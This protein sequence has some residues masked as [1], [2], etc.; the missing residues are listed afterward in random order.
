MIK[1]LAVDRLHVVGDIFDRGPRADSIM[2]ILMQRRSVDIEWGNHDVLWMGAASGSECCIAAVL[3]N[4]LSYGNTT[5][6]ERGYG[7]PLRELALFAG[8][9]YPQLPLDK[10]A[11]HA[12]TVIMFTLEGQL[13]VTPTEE[14]THP[15]DYT[16]HIAGASGEKC[17][18]PTI[19]NN[20]C[21]LS[22]A[23]ETAGAVC[24]YEITRA[25]EGN[26]VQL[27]STADY[28]VSVWAT[29]AGYLDSDVATTTITM[30]RGD[31]NADGVVSITDAVSVV[32]II[33]SG[34]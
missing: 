32:N 22:F 20:N 10:A 11:A 31:V 23:C 28:V 19:T 30:K 29:K 14:A 4:C 2:E 25:G 27:S 9:N 15:D 1:N 21:T 17:A 5:I 26:T 33:N 3:R 18:T 8:R 6:L 13:I 34:F 24:H 12:V 16:Y 7:I